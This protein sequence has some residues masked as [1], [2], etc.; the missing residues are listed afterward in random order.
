MKNVL[1]RLA[2]RQEGVVAV[3]QLRAAGLGRAAVEHQVRELLQLQD[4]VYLTGAGPPSRRQRMWAAALTAPGRFISHASA[5]DA[6]GF[7]PWTGPFEVVTAPGTGG[8]KRLPSLLVCR[9]TTLQGSTTTLDGLPITTPERALADLARPLGA[10]EYARCVRE[11]LRLK[12]T[13]CA[14]IQVF[15]TR[16]TPRNRPR[17]LTR[18]AARYARLPIARAASDPESHALEI[19][20]AAGYPTPL[21]NRTIAGHKPDLAWPH[22]KHIVELDGPDFHQFPEEDLKKQ[23]AWERAGW[24]VSRLP[25]GDVYENPARLLAAA[26]PALSS[27]AP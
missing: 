10:D 20:D 26:E 21:V 23:A 7:R 4:G 15:L 19:L 2:A 9:S 13:T 17:A 18:L 1:L 11:A 5:G 3:W 24:S 25:T 16:Q 8:P 14:R 12:V 22:A 6:F 27:R